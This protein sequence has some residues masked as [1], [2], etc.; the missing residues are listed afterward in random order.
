MPASRLLE[1]Q[2]SK[3]S[4]AALALGSLPARF[5]HTPTPTEVSRRNLEVSVKTQRKKPEYNGSSPGEVIWP[6]AQ[7]GD[8][9][10]GAHCVLPGHD[11]PLVL[12]EKN[13]SATARRPLLMLLPDGSFD[14]FELD[15]GFR[16]AHAALVSG[17]AVTVDRAALEMVGWTRDLAAPPMPQ[18]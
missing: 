6:L 12:L 14:S 15:A 18:V 16:L 5:S 10:L 8:L 13:P 9:R 7:V 11:Q 17:E 4:F 2:F 1:C 3:G